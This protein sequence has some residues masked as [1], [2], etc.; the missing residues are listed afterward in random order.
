MGCPA[1]FLLPSLGPGPK[2]LESLLPSALGRARKSPGFS[3][4]PIIQE[5]ITLNRH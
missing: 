5:Q 1:G 3:N 2:P 4:N